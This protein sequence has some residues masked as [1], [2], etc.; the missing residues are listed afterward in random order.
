MSP[1]R[2]IP[3][4]LIKPV[5]LPKPVKEPETSSSFFDFLPFWKTAPAT[6][7]PAKSALSRTPFPSRRPVPSNR[8]SGAPTVTKLKQAP[9][10]ADYPAGLQAPVLLKVGSPN[11]PPQEAPSRPLTKDSPLNTARIDNR[12]YTEGED[13]FVVL[14]AAAPKRRGPPPPRRPSGRPLSPPRPKNPRLSSGPLPMTSQPV[15]GLPQVP[16]SRKQSPFIAKRPQLPPRVQGAFG[17]NKVHAQVV[18]HLLY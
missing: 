7:A 1:L 17:K 8:R 4:P 5:P 6:P 2:Q 11:Y 18:N 10:P 15:I 3:R 12:I 14:P 16:P 13:P 9:K